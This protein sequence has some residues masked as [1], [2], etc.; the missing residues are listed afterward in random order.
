AR[1]RHHAHRL[2]EDA[3]RLVLGLVLA[4]AVGRFDEE[5]VRV[6]QDR[7]VTDDRRP[8]PAEVPG[9]DDRG[10]PLGT[11]VVAAAAAG[12]LDPKADDRRAE[13]VAGIEERRVD[14]GRD[15]AFLVVAD[16]IEAGDRDL[17]IVD[18]VE[19]LIEIGVHL[20]RL[21]PERSLWVGGR[22]AGRR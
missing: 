3:D 17:G 13:D 1:V 11:A 6:A 22:P 14:A 12:R 2:G 21:A 20:G 15:L 19:R 7:R 10:L 4:A 5:V 16:R 9:E 18:R 8:G